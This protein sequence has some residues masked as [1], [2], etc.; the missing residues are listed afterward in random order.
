[1][2]KGRK[3]GKSGKDSRSDRPDDYD[4]GYGRPPREHRFKEGQSGNPKGRPKGRKNEDTILHEI[5]YRKISITEGGRTR[6]APYIE[7]MLLRFAKDALHGDA[8]AAAFLL[9]RYGARVQGDAVENEELAPDDQ[10]ILVAYEQRIRNELKEQ[11][12]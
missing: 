5:L 1:M 6:K 2:K 7:V 4:V 12:K 9:N 3:G 11:E 8:K 10:D